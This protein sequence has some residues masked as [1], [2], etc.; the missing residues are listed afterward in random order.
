MMGS[1]SVRPLAAVRVS[2]RRVL[3]SGSSMEQLCSSR[4]A[5]G[6]CCQSLHCSHAR[7]HQLSARLSAL[8]VGGIV[9]RVRVLR[10][11]AVAGGVV[12][13]AWA[14]GQSLHICIRSISLSIPPMS[15]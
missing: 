12:D 6:S 15:K 11:R 8:K 2:Q 9:E 10:V 14:T 1:S 13:D 7:A 5:P 4:R 3:S